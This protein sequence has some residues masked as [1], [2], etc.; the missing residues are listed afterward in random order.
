M[1]ATAQADR[2]LHHARLGV[3]GRRKLAAEVRRLRA[4][5]KL[6]ADMNRFLR[7]HVPGYGWLG[8]M[9]PGADPEPLPGRD[10]DVVA[11]VNDRVRTRQPGL[12]AFCA[13]T[14][15]ERA[16]SSRGHFRAL[17]NDAVHTPMYAPHR[18][19]PAL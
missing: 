9:K 17:T 12:A 14:F 15:T 13:N 10:L 16:S 4:V 11:A 1:Q 5:G 19:A 6:Q 3:R 2:Q 7:C 8:V 18:D